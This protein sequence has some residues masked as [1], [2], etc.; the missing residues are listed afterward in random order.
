[1]LGGV[2]NDSYFVDNAA[3]VVTE[4]AGEG[5]AHVSTPASATP[6]PRVPR[7]RSCGRTP[8]TG[9]TLTGNEFANTIVGGTGNDTLIGGGGNDT[10]NGGAGNDTLNGGAGNDSSTAAPAP[11]PWP[12]APATT[13]TTST[14]P[15]TW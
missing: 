11:T 3:D 9:L 14:T 15:A 13:A 1:M 5:T 12:V 7:S 6:S 8:A 2:G 10:L 4:N